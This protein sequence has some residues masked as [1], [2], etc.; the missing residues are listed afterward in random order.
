MK[1]KSLPKDDNTV[2]LALRCLDRNE[3][4]FASPILADALEDAG[5]DY[6]PLLNTLRKPPEGGVPDRY[7][8]GWGKLQELVMVTPLND[9]NWD[10][11]F[12]YAGEPNAGDGSASINPAPP[13]A[14][15]STDPFSR[16]DVE[17][18]FG[19]ADGDNDGP[20]WLMYGKLR[21]GRFFF[22]TAGCDYTGWG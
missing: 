9:G 17:K 5:Y 20:N 18:V 6:C 1:I 4:P 13:F 8:E 7:W 16:W 14:K 15:I 19:Y 22:I 3:F 11:V 12:A 2:G 21:D 10:S